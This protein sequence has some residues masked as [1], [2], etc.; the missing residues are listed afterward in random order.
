MA[1][2]LSIRPVGETFPDVNGPEWIKYL[3]QPQ[4]SRFGDYYQLAWFYG[5]A[6]DS[7]NP[8]D[9]FINRQGRFQTRN[10]FQ[11]LNG[12]GTPNNLIH[13]E[14]FKASDGTQYL[15][16]WTTTGVQYGTTGGFSN[17][18]GPALSLSLSTFISTTVWGSYLLFTDETSGVYKI[19]VSAG[20]YALITGSPI[21]KHITTF[22]GRVVASNIS[23]SP[24]RIQW[25]VKNDSDDWSGIG[26]GFEDLAS[27][28]G[29]SSDIQHGVFPLN[30][31]D[32]MIVRAGTIWMMGLTGVVTAPFQFRFLYVQKIDA[33]KSISASP[34]G[35]YVL[36]QRGPVLLTLG[37]PEYITPESQSSIFDGNL[38]TYT[39][40]SSY[41]LYDEYNDT[42]YLYIPLT[43]WSGDSV[44]WVYTREFK[45]WTKWTFQF[46]I[47]SM[48]VTNFVLT[49]NTY[50]TRK[51]MF[52]T[53][54]NTGTSCRIMTSYSA[55]SQ[56]DGTPSTDHNYNGGTVG[57]FGLI[58]FFAMYE[59]AGVSITR[60]MIDLSGG[61][62][63]G[64][65]A[66]LAIASEDQM[67]HSLD[68]TTYVSAT[69]G[70]SGVEHVRKYANVVKSCLKGF[71]CRITL[72]AGVILNGIS[73]H[74]QPWGKL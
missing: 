38:Q 23:G 70:R 59:H 42:Y 9:V 67:S 6:D 11:T 34:Y 68:N 24:S 64:G 48:A 63:A 36:A 1:K 12:S 37:G 18:T 72:D 32:A 41:G 53:Q 19:D 45:V 51:P 62:A 31:T 65:N 29:G 44:V 40:A 27:G 74:Q 28:P 61:A 50:N 21:C 54:T 33:R 25:T 47:K 69:L 60:A 26:S 10:G 15:I 71:W 35:L 73:L 49:S 43:T 5:Q 52:T 13:T 14:P 8:T 20:T 58:E 7:I 56:G 22:G 2:P 3:S 55:T 17:L 30:D 57:V 4:T 46:H 66:T 16:R 39:Y